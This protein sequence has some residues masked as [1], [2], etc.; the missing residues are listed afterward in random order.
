MLLLALIHV[1]SARVCECVFGE[2]HRE[3]GS[4]NLVCADARVC[5]LG[6]QLG[7]ERR[8]RCQTKP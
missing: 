3:S 5:V 8:K 4:V 1:A 6:V 7:A 2:T